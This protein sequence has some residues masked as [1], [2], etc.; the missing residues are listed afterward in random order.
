[1]SSITKHYMKCDRCGSEHLV[2]PELETVR[3]TIQGPN[4]D[5]NRYGIDLCSACA[6]DLNNFFNKKDLQ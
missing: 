5:N 4:I 3:V 2:S 6:K 1:M